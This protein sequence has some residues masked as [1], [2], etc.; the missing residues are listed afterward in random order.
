MLKLSLKEEV[1]RTLNSICALDYMAMN[2]VPHRPVVLSYWGCMHCLHICDSIEIKQFQQPTLWWTHPTPTTK[3]VYSSSPSRFVTYSVEYILLWQLNIIPLMWWTLKV[4]YSVYNIPPL[5]VYYSVYNIPPLKVYYSVY[6]IP[7]LK[8]Y[9]S[10]YNI[11]PLP[12]WRAWILPTFRSKN[13]FR[14]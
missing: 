11:P 9:Y 5:K 3:L 8:V 12:Q 13:Q 1:V 7:P 14:K 4:Y 6:N 10:V 2:W